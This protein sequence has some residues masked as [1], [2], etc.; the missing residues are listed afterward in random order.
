MTEIV[1]YV[2][3]SLDGF[4]ATPD[5]GV[6]WLAPFESSAEDY[7]Y[8]AFYASVDAVLLGRRTYE[9]ALTFGPWP[10]GDNRVWVFSHGDLAPAAAGVR[11]TDRTPDEIAAELDAQGVRR[12]WLV[13]GA[14][15]AA[16]FREAG[17]ITEYI[18]SVMPVV[19]GGGVPLFAGLGPQECLR[20]VESTAFADGV[21]QLRYERAD[22]AR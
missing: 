16:S 1:Y 19:L 6:A 20:L 7:G 17:L 22:V 3:M 5:G 12:A 15:L 21:V 10:Y 8:G 11:V 14:A 4:I 13:G 9:Q 2:A 18:V